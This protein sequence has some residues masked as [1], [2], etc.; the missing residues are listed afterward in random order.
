MAQF[1]IELQQVEQ[2]INDYKKSI[3]DFTNMANSL[4]PIINELRTSGW[5]SN[6]G[7]AYFEKY[8]DSW[9]K[10]FD[11][12]IKILTFLKECLIEAKRDYEQ[13]Y[14]QSKQLANDI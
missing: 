12:H 11:M 7:N 5:V 9:K 3:D 10:N 4:V 1:S 6:A 13:L 8:N 2:S 14:E